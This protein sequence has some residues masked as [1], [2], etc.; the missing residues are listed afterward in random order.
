MQLESIGEVIA[1]RRL[2]IAND[3]NRTIWVKMGKPQPL[4]DALGD[5]HFCPFQINGVGSEKVKYAAGVD[6]FQSIELAFRGID[7]E[8]ALLNQAHDGKLRWEGD[9]H[10]NLGFL[11]GERVRE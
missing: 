5:D 7:A 8:L 9:E 4:A 10:G 1:V 11:L 3:P 6:G 2:S